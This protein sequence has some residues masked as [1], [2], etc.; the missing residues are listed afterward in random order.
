MCEKLEH[1][2]I[3]FNDSIKNTA[4]EN[5]LF[6]SLQNNLK[7]VKPNNIQALV[8]LIS[9]LPEDRHSSAQHAKLYYHSSRSINQLPVQH[10]AK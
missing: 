1:S 5:I 9:T 2:V 10:K 7:N 8:H 6:K 3:G 4:N